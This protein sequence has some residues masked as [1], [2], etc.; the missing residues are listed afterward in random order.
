MIKEEIFIPLYHDLCFKEVLARKENREFLEFFLEVLLNFKRGYLHHKL[1]VEYESPIPKRNIFEKSMRADLLVYFDN[2]VIN[3]ECYSSFNKNAYEKTMCYAMKLASTIE[4]GEDYK[5]IKPVIQLVF[6]DNV[7]IK[8]NKDVISDYLITNTKDIENTLSADKFQIHY[9]RLDN[10][11]T[12]N[13]NED[14][15]IK[16]IRFLGANSQ[17]ERQEIARGS[18]ILMEFDSKLQTYVMDEKTKKMFEEWDLEILRSLK[19]EKEKEIKEAV[20][21]AVKKAVNK[22]VKKAENKATKMNVQLINNMI[23]ENFSY[24]MIA[25]ITGLSQKKIKELVAPKRTK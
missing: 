17:K 25:K 11:R 15:K 5:E 6:I 22:A 13:Y 20:N 10:A 23:N 8:F 14:I 18:K 16:L 9:F 2:F 7:S 12:Y 3:L 4:S 21:K 24:E 1:K 19:E